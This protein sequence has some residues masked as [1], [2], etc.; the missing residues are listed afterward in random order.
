MGGV[1]W[2]TEWEA[3]FLKTIFLKA[4][5]DELFECNYKKEYFVSP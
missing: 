3:D 4:M 5:V 1:N 2:G